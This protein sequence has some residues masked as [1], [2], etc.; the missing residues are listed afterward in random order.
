MSP[1]P[2]VYC[3][4]RKDVRYILVGSDG[5]WEEENIEDICST[6]LEDL[7]TNKRT[8]LDFAVES[9]LDK[10]VATDPKSKKGKDNL[11]AVA[12]RFNEASLCK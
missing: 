4:H 5:I 11:T 6:L 8:N 1:I 7:K 2:D 3:L 12:I 9:Y 10:I